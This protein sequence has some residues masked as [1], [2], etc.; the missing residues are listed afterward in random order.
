[1]VTTN[2]IEL[3][4]RAWSYKDHGKNYDKIF[5]NEC[6]PG[7]F[8]WVHDSIGTNWRLTEMQASI[9][10]DSLD[11]LEEWINIRRNNADIFNKAFSDI[12]FIRCTIPDEKYYHAYYKYYCFVKPDFLPN[13]ITRDSIIK[14]INDLGVPCF[15]GTCGEVYREKAYNLDLNLPVTQEL[16]KTSLMFLV[17]P[18]YTA[19]KINEITGLIRKLLLEL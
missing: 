19:E 4:K 10:I 17:D 18:T 7:L 8:K 9:G 3:A 16:T 5:N 2:N 12:S 6:Q 15:Q 14:K 13:G 11:C 1:M